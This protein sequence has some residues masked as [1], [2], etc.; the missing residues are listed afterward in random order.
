MENKN[1]IGNSLD[2]YINYYTDLSVNDPQYSW[3]KDKP[4]TI[5]AMAQK[6]WNERQKQIEKEQKQEEKKQ[7]IAEHREDSRRKKEQKNFNTWSESLDMSRYNYDDTTGNIVD[8]TTGQ[9]ITDEQREQFKKNDSIARK[10]LK[11]VENYANSGV[12]RI[13]SQGTTLGSLAKAFGEGISAIAG[14]DGTVK[15]ADFAGYL[16]RLAAKKQIM[17]PPGKE[18]YSTQDAEKMLKDGFAQYNGYFLPAAEYNAIQKDTKNSQNK[19]VDYVNQGKGAADSYFN[20]DQSAADKIQELES[21]GLTTNDI[22]NYFIGLYSG[23]GGLSDN[24][25]KALNAYEVKKTENKKQPETTIQSNSKNKNPA[26]PQG[27]EPY[28]AGDRTALGREINTVYNELYNNDQKE[29]IER[30]IDK[31]N[32]GFKSKVGDSWKDELNDAWGAKLEYLKKHPVS[33]IA[34]YLGT[35]LLNAAAIVK[36]GSANAQSIF[37]KIEQET[38]NGALQRYNAKRDKMLEDDASLLGDEYKNDQQFLTQLKQLYANKELMR[39]V[40]DLDVSTRTAL[41]KAYKQVADSGVFGDNAQDIITNILKIGAVQGAM[42]GGLPQAVSQTAGTAVQAVG[43]IAG[44]AANTLF[45]F[46]TK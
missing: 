12:Y 14:G 13:G 7:S 5:K 34:N 31:Y 28:V 11:D 2:D 4:D 21:E 36:N 17:L 29:A 33:S 39:K 42:E 24:A 27:D 43:N 8:S 30:K 9:P 35:S 26:A 3:Y 23:K 41:L 37:N 10:N 40:Q 38:L 32:E 45:Q 20:S 6:Q 1:Y 15:P 16:N 18:R 44:G 25:E 46:L 22:K 19:A